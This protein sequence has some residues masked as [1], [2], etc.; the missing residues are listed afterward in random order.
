VSRIE[1]IGDCTLYLGDCR[2]VLPIIGSVDCV[3]TSPPYGEMR[4]YGEA[5]TGFNWQDFIGPIRASIKDGS[6]LVWNVADQQK[7]GSE[8]GDSMRQALAFMDAGLRLHDTMIYTKPSF[9]F[10]ESNRYPQTWEYMF[11]FSGGSPKTFNP[12]KDRKNIYSGTKVH[13]TQRQKDGSTVPA[14]GNGKI[15]SEYGARHNVWLINNRE[16]DN[17]GEHPAPFPLALA[18]DHIRTWTNAGCSVADPFMGS[19][20]TGVA[21]VKLGRKFIG[22]ERE[23]KYFEIACRRI[24]EAY[25]Q[26][27]F[28]IEPPKK[29][30]QENLI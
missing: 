4:D 9:S 25:A 21:C 2:D 22:I 13:G 3:V 19:G 23:P 18:A 7:S 8:S 29:M 24:R 12:I 10:P 16:A 5:F 11:V 6:V 27:D 30:E 20:T 1:Q 26:P 28:F 17:T 14:T 15:L